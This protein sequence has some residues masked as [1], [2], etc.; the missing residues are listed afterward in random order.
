MINYKIVLIADRLF[1][2][3][4]K[5]NMESN[6]LEKI[7]DSYFNYIYNAL[8]EISLG[9]IHYNDLKTFID[10]ID[11]HADD[12]VF[13]IYGGQDSRN[14]MAL[15]PAICEAYQIKYVG[16][17][18]YNRIICQDKDISKIV[19]KK[20]G[21]RIAKHIVINEKNIDNNELIHKLKLPIV[22]KPL[23]EGS[24]IGITEQSLCHNYTDALILVKK[25][26]KIYNQPIMIEEFIPGKE[27]VT[28]IIGNANEIKICETVERY[29][30]NNA[31]YFNDH[32][33]TGE[34]KFVNRNN[35]RERI[36]TDKL[37]KE[38]YLK[39]IKAFKQFGKMD[40]MRID[41]RL[42]GNK[43]YFIEFTPDASLS[44]HTPFT[45]IYR[46]IGKDYKD[47]LEDIIKSALEN[48]LIL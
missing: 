34:S 14:R 44:N 20:L 11:R 33:F 32:L 9:V 15:V 41:G 22:V 18:A 24:S 37:C 47:A 30:K 28:C 4:D 48:Y 36:V 38:D 26:L 10:N 2:E 35:I 12:I 7:D 45:F 13:T 5:I 17:D 27:V 6:I 8:K 25:Y 39:F 1:K 42:V 46:N 19:A 3:K 40:Y 31:D 21:F 29:Y 43:F 16:A 23:F